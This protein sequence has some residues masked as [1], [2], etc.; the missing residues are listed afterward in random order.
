MDDK[1]KEVVE[2]YELNIKNVYRVRGAYILDTG[3]G[4]R[5]LREFRSTPQKAEFAQL[6]KES[7]REQGYIYTDLYLR[8]REGDLITENVMGNQYVLKHRFMGEECDLKSKEQVAGAAENLAKLHNMMRGVTTEPLTFQADT[9]GETL[10]KHNRE[11]RRVRSYIREK[12]QRNEFELLFLSIFSEFYQEAEDAESMLSDI[13]GEGLYQ[14]L[15]EQQ[16]LCHGSYNYHNVLFTSSGIATTSFERTH[17]QLQVMDLYDF[18]R[19]LMEKNNWN[20]YLLQ[21]VLEHYQKVRPLSKEEK[22]LLYIWMIYPEK[23]WKITN[24]YYNSKKTWMSGKNIE[25]LQGLQQQK[26]QR[27]NL[28]EKVPEIL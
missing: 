15:N 26:K 7:L 10:I 24:F 4:L 1:I 11:L 27:M 17:L 14:E 5:I 12:K 13:E 25:K 20:L 28:L 6:V 9:F 3:E 22:K 8:N 2:Q 21:T 16:T 23:F 18:V 19:K